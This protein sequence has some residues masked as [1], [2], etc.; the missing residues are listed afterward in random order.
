MDRIITEYFQKLEFGELQKFKNMEVIPLFVSMNHSPKYLTLE[1]ALE[2]RVLTITEVSHEGS[3]PELKVVNKANTHVLLLDGEE[4]AGAKQNR[5]LNTTIL[6][7]K[8]SET[9]IPVSCAEQGRWS[10][11]SKEFTNSGIISS[12]KLRAKKNY[13]V[14]K[15][16]EQS[17]AY[18]ANQM[19]I[20]DEV[21]KMSSYAGVRSKTDAM[22]DIFE[23]KMKDLDEYLK[24][25]K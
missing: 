22:R 6:L 16:L 13:S 2:K 25:F 7:K 17:H 15:T 19:E 20:W 23:S 11:V 3:V 18:L 9:V 24:S 10:H 14:A 4:V 1:E 8:K 21:Y 5:I 12:P